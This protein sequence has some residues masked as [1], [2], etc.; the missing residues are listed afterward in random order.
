MR[1]IRF[2]HDTDIDGLH[3]EPGD[4]TEAEDAVAFEL[5]QAHRVEYID[6]PA[7]E[8]APE[9]EEGEAPEPETAPEAGEAE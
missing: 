8:D 5:F 7:P 4:V 1:V 6:G 2:R 3:F 9:A